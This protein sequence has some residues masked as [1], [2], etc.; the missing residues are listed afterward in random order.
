MADLLTL[1]LTLA[2]SFLGFAGFYFSYKAL[3]LYENDIMHRVFA[4]MSVAF[5]VSGFITVF[6]AVFL[7]FGTSF[8]SYP[9]LSVA[10]IISTCS[11][12]IGLVSLLRWET[13]IRRE[14][15]AET[16]TVS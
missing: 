4:L 15:S 11:L 2:Y 6:D 12:L 1:V 13:R 14:A 3:K 8:A 7:A 16:T 5:L 9:L 10:G